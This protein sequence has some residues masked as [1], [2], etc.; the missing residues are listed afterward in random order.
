MAEPLAYSYTDAAQATGYSIDII[1]KAVAKGDLVPV[2]PS[3]D[4]KQITKPVIPADELKRWLA[5]A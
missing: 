4:G 3:I 5:A 1:K 2:R